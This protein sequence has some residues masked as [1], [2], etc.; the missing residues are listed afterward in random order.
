MPRPFTVTVTSGAAEGS[1]PSFFCTESFASEADA[2]HWERM[3]EETLSRPEALWLHLR[4]YGAGL[5]ETI[6][7]HGGALAREKWLS[8]E[9]SPEDWAMGRPV[10][11]QAQDKISKLPS[12]RRRR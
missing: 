2:K 10:V 4:V 6:R 1:Q 9:A 5:A 11:M 3:V 8:G 7:I 12:L